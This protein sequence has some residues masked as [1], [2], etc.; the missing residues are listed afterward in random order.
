MVDPQRAR[1]AIGPHDYETKYRI[2]A[3]NT[4]DWE[5]WLS[6]DN[7]YV[8]VSPSSKRITG[9]D[10]EDFLS[11]P[12]LRTRIIHPEDLDRFNEHTA[13][14]EGQE[15]MGEMELRIRHKD[16]RIRWISHACQPIFD[17]VGR[18]L[19][20]RGCNRD[21]TARKDTEA[22][23]RRSE[24]FTERVL[25]S[26][27][28]GLYIHDL[29]RGMNTFVNPEYTR[30]TGYKLEDIN[31]MTAEEFCALFHEEDRARVAAHMKV[32]SQA[33]DGEVLEVEY[34]FRTS[35]SRWIWCLSRDAAF[36][37]DED[38]SVRQ[39]VGT[40]LDLTARKEAEQ[41]LIEAKDELE[42]R[43]R[44]RTA[45][46]KERN[47]LLE[48]IFSNVHFLVAYLDTEFNFIRVNR[49]YSLADGRD[50][51]F[52]PGKNHF[53][54]YP[55]EENEAIFRK[56]V[57]SGAPFQ[58]M[59]RPFQYPDSPD[60]GVTYWDWSLHPVKDLRDEV[61][62][63]ILSLV[64]VT[65][66]K[67]A[68]QELV[69]TNRELE[70][71]RERLQAE[72]VYL[73][74]EISLNHNFEP[75]IGESPALKS[76]LKL[77][78]QV[79][80]TDATVLIL[81]ETGTGKELMA[82]AIH[83]HSRRSHQPLIKVDCAAIPPT[84]IETELFGH[85]KGSFTGATKSRV[86]RIALADGGTIFLDEIGELPKDIQ[87]KLLRVLQEGE[88]EQ[89]G[90][91]HTQKVDIRVIAATNRD[92]WSAVQDGEF[93]MDLYYRLSVFPVRVPPLRERGD[94]IV[95][96][97]SFFVEHFAQKMGKTFQPLSPECARHLM[98][99]EWPG[100]VRELQNVIER[101]IITA[102]GGRL[103]CARLV[104]STEWGASAERASP[105]TPPG[106]E[107]I[108]TIDALHQLE[109][110][111]LVRALRKTGWR[112]SGEKGAARL[113]GMPPSTLSSRIRAL[114]IEK[115]ASPRPVSPQS[116][117]RTP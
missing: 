83:S 110:E 102:R 26:S 74:E 2:V 19:G 117:R 49:A 103:D 16:G 31:S 98:E 106:N 53:D 78:E 42:D 75:I 14:V 77:V 76:V 93:R 62:G 20:V 68:Q 104:A 30:I 47:D 37:R 79:S 24:A 41:G 88:F 40:F 18:Y 33:G 13:Q 11:D 54:L 91:S 73:Q 107:E 1:P 96:L 82:R 55:S 32:L 112:V 97:A 87:S 100:N 63:L 81:G 115:S 27:L 5:F 70:A 8:Y 17:E 99:Y 69:K 12:E 39:F 58:V 46:L 45:E 25:M 94:D 108:L 43:V 109:R 113:L 65:E 9:Y 72:N 36:L 44:Q 4:Y 59:G 35:D 22:A 6:P 61:V 66:Q 116:S 34:R 56:V 86:G 51:D 7:R 15:G 105:R 95:E 21:I 23:L 38:G 85:E 89:V 71:L 57:E 52:F 90:S 50:Q 10:A 60:R 29:K 114:G 84:L 92:L 101:A 64:D 48:V 28:A 3:N 111:N 80:S 67:R